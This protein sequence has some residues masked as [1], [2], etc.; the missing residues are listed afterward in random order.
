MEGSIP[1]GKLIIETVW[2]DI[3]LLTHT[4]IVRLQLESAKAASK[5]ELSVSGAFGF[6]TIHQVRL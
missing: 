1:V 5:L 3:K 6:R 4:Y 2:H